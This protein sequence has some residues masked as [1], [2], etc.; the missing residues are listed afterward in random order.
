MPGS[1]FGSDAL[2]TTHLKRKNHPAIPHRH[3]QR[4]TSIHSSLK[5]KMLPSS[6]KVYKTTMTPQ[7]HG[8]DC[9]WR[10]HDFHPPVHKEGLPNNSTRPHVQ[11][12]NQD[13]TF[14]FQQ[15]TATQTSAARRRRGARQRDPRLARRPG[16]AISLGAWIAYNGWNQNAPPYKLIKAPHLHTKT[17]N[18]PNAPSQVGTN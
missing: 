6:L 3:C 13:E 4:E 7:C 17:K 1:A 5:A 15:R 2:Q 9:D 14:T 18:T 16:R 8:R 10:P 11:V 12:T